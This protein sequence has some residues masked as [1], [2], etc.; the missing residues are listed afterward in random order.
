MLKI[1]A[2]AFV[3]AISVSSCSVTSD[4]ASAADRKFDTEKYCYYA[5][6]AYSEGAVM[7]QN[8]FEAR[9]V[10]ATDSESS[11]TVSANVLVWQRLK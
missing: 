4:N 11:S 3:V 5:S 9:C 7:D 1:P 6:N 10:R 2:T 8:G